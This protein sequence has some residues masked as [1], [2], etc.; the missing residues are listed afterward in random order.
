MNDVLQGAPYVFY[1]I[2]GAFLGLSALA[3]LLQR[4]T[5]GQPLEDVLPVSSK[6]MV[7]TLSAEDERQLQR[8]GVNDC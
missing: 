8:L 6:R 2:I 5:R 3:P 4:E 1:V 7:S